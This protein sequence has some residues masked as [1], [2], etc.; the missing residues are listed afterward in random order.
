VSIT[1]DGLECNT[2][3][4][5]EKNA[6]GSA[7][8]YG[9]VYNCVTGSGPTLIG[10]TL[11]WVEAAA[12][13]AAALPAVNAAHNPYHWG[14]N[15]APGM[16][17]QGLGDDLQPY[18][19]YN[20]F[21]YDDALRDAINGTPQS[22][23]WRINPPAQVIAA[24]YAAD[25]VN[26]SGLASTL[27]LMRDVCAA[28][29]MKYLQYMGRLDT[30]DSKAL[31]EADEAAWR[32]RADAALDYMQNVVGADAVAI[33]VS[34]PYGGF[35]RYAGPINGISALAQSRF[36]RWFAEA[37][38]RRELDPTYPLVCVEPWPESAADAS[39]PRQ[40]NRLLS[41]QA[42]GRALG[43]PAYI[44]NNDAKQYGPLAANP[45][46]WMAPLGDHRWFCAQHA[47]DETPADVRAIVKA[48]GVW[49]VS[50]F[51]AASRTPLLPPRASA[52]PSI[53]DRSAY[54][55]QYAPSMGARGRR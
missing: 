29:G 3:G 12:A 6:S 9:C 44:N 53:D 15:P 50:H 47:G 48:G 7:A 36:E 40:S 49:C 54:H 38:R 39:N 4:Y 17:Q 14:V 25:T 2:H 27:R 16:I 51:E 32:A 18:P 42:T 28:R 46:S 43:V 11:N 21:A 37:A 5:P 45:A 10:P 23:S 31:I 30:P 1:L 20:F 35:S 33:D 19:W 52:S 26:R 8:E 13:W 55:Q 34:A 24:G 22:P 41:P